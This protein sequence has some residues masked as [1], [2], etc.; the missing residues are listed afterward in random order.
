M[1]TIQ[2]LNF[3]YRRGSNLF[4]DLSLRIPK[5]GIYGLLGKNGAGKTSLLKI[6]SG[7]CFP[8][9]G[10][11]RVFDED[12]VQRKPAFLSDLYLL[13]EDLHV[14]PVTPNQYCKRFG[15]FYK[16]FDLSLYEDAVKQFEVPTR[17]LLT[18]M[19]HGQKKKFLIAFGLA[20]KARLFILDEPTNGLDIP[21]KALFRQLLVTHF[22]EDRIFI[23]S[24]HQVHDVENLID[25]VILL[26]SGKILF[27][28]STDEISQ[29]LTFSA[30][31]T[32]PS[33]DECLYYEKELGGY[34]VIAGSSGQQETE[35][36]LELLFNGIL[37]NSLAFE[38]MLNQK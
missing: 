30:Q 20:T 15:P 25:H 14:P 11:C 26:D 34:R 21:S 38:E 33:V 3:Q 22:S 2:D 6:L 7:L 16:N 32:E 23:I 8:R 28:H 31:S 1:I 24:T 12:P 9:S 35:I 36:N 5:G 37:L 18:K 29:R 19:S 13:P 27:N 17:Q 4:S 10:Y